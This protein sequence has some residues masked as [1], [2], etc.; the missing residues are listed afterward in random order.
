MEQVR[1]LLATQNYVSGERL[2]TAV[3]LALSL[4]RPLFLEG[5]AGVGKTELGVALGRGAWTAAHPPA[6]P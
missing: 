6:M 1:D 3:F 5:E 4:K 2:G